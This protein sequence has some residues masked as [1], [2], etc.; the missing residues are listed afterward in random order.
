M[1]RSLC[2]QD[3]QAKVLPSLVRGSPG[4]ISPPPPETFPKAGPSLYLCCASYF[5][6][7][8]SVELQRTTKKYRKKY[9]MAGLFFFFFLGGGGGGGTLYIYIYMYI[10]STPAP[11]DLC[12]FFLFYHSPRPSSDLPFFALSQFTQLHC[13][14]TQCALLQSVFPRA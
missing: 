5:E 14:Q 1:C 11:I 2:G 3:T 9:A 10:Y 8:P 6:S 7:G 4:N 12:L 13:K